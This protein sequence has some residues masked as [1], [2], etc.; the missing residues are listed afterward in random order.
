M[1]VA[2]HLFDHPG[3][4]PVSDEPSSEDDT[5]HRSA[6]VLVSGGPPG[7]QK[8]RG[9]RPR[10][11]ERVM[12]LTGSPV[13]SFLCD[14]DTDRAPIVVEPRNR[15]TAPSRSLSPHPERAAGSTCGFKGRF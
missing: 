13:A 1:S 12:R 4:P 10:S 11:P 2:V 15:G 5:A 7:S 14:N 6:D 9:I 8:K 3:S